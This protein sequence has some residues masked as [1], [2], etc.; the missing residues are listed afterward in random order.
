MAEVE[1]K[2]SKVSIMRLKSNQS[3]KSQLALGPKS[4]S[5]LKVRRQSFGFSGVPGIRPVE[6]TSQVMKT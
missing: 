2:K 5:R 1:S 4:L 3:N 6:R